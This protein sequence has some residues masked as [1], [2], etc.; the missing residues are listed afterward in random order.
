MRDPER[1]EGFYEELKR[2]HKQR[3]PDWR[4][5]Q[6]ITA[7][8]MWNGDPFSFEEDRFLEKFSEFADT[9]QKKGR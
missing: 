8:I 7:F 9:I 5:G 4:F 6:L 3:F 1:L 2:I